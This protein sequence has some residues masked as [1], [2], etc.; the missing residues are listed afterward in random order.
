MSTRFHTVFAILF[1]LLLGACK[2]TGGVPDNAQTTVLSFKE[3]DCAMCGEEMAK[4][5]IET[6]GVHKTAFDKRKAELTVVADRKLDVLATAKR[7]KPPKEEWEL[8]LGAGKGGYLPWQQVPTGVDVKQVAT[9]GED[10]PDLAPH[11]VR[12]KVTIVDFSA[13]WCEPCRELDEHVLGVVA[14]RP[15]VAWTRRSATAI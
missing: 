13:K 2:S 10:V 4:S 3:L 9:D 5:L 15:D 11:I 7:L 14:K 6:E 12:G 1:A 8:V